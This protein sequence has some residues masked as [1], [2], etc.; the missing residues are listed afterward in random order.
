MV[1]AITNLVAHFTTPWAS[2]A[3]VPA[4][5]VGLLILVRSRGLGWAELGLEPRSLEIGRRI[6]AGGRGRRDDGHRD[7]GDAAV[8]PADVHEQ[9]LRHRVRR[10]DRVDD[11]HPAADGDPRR[12]G[13]SR[14]AAR[15]AEPGV[16]IPWRRGSGFAAV[17]P[18]AH[19]HLVGPHQQQCRIHPDLRRRACSARSPVWCSPS[20]PPAWPVSYSPGCAAAAAACWRPIALHWSLNGLG[21][22]AAALVWHLS[23][24]P[25]AALAG[26]EL[27]VL[28]F[29]SAR[30]HFAPGTA[31][32]AGPV[33]ERPLTLPVPARLQPRPGSVPL[34]VA[35][36][37][38]QLDQAGQTRNRLRW[39]APPRRG[40]RS[41][42][43]RCP[44]TRPRAAV[45]SSAVG[46]GPPA[47][48]TSIARRAP[49]TPRRSSR[50]EACSSASGVSK[51]LATSQGRASAGSARRSGPSGSST[52]LTSSCTRISGSGAGLVS[53][54]AAQYVCRD[55][56]TPV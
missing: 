48:W 50:S 23:I 55:D 5:A 19:R 14:C 46:A 31:M 13:V 43:A 8:D 51:P 18:L 16:G 30:G 26:A 47:L 36:D 34:G 54:S 10:A 33:V 27:A 20:S 17:R 32:V 15:R 37:Q 56:M 41:R 28:E 25:S 2:I 35:D 11:H 7:R 40:R 6:C 22:L 4:A 39:S 52:V 45:P 9:Q 1:L 12:A 49:R 3:T 21:A 38:Q 29:V 44:R 53:A 24:D 42:L